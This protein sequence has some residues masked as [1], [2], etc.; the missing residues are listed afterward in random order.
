MD[1]DI[2]EELASILEGKANI[3]ILKTKAKKHI[4]KI[5]GINVL[6]EKF[7]VFYVCVLSRCEHISECWDIRNKKLKLRD[8]WANC[9]LLKLVDKKIK[10]R[11][12]KNYFLAS[13]IA[14]SDLEHSL[15]I[16]IVRDYAKKVNDRK[17][18]ELLEKLVYCDEIEGL[19]NVEA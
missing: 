6:A 10:E 1:K 9:K 17:V 15:L 7:P 18:D 19:K 14:F 2:I 13:R 8:K 4:Y 5:H 11:R 16:A 3:G 12:I